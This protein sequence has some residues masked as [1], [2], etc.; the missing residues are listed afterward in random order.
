VDRIQQADGSFMICQMELPT[1]SHIR[2]RVCRLDQGPSASEQ[3][4]NRQLLQPPAKQLQSG[5]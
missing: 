1:G 3:E 4:A 5:N 2:E